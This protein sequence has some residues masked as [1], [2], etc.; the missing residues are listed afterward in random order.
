MRK[1]FKRKAEVET[2][3]KAQKTLLDYGFPEVPTTLKLGEKTEN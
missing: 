1:V 2:R 3:A